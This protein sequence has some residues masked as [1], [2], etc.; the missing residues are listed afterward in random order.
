MVIDQVK[1]KTYLQFEWEFLDVV[2][3]KKTSVYKT[4]SWNNIVS[5]KVLLTSLDKHTRYGRPSNKS[6]AELLTPPLL[7]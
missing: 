4:F 7:A 5:Y 2:K 3:F 6:I 1:R